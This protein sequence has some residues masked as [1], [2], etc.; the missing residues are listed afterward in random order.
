MILK[1]DV[2]RVRSLWFA[3]S[4]NWYVYA[5]NS[6]VIYLDLDGL[7]Y[8]GWGS[9]DKNGNHAKMGSNPR[10]DIYYKILGVCLARKYLDKYENS[11]IAWEKSRTARDNSP[12]NEE[13]RNAEHYLYAFTSV[14]KGLYLDYYN[15][16]VPS[17]IGSWFFMTF[18]LTPGYSTMKY[19][20]NILGDYT[21][22]DDS[23]RV[24]RATMDELASGYAGGH[25]GL[26]KNFKNNCECE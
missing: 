7:R 4:R 1:L 20:S 23:F 14:N 17:G 22:Y 19:G 21:S 9:W 18:V 25:D 6:P 24:S 2:G 13:L 10:K 3:G 26:D 15:V 8:K 5:G 16:R 11:D 12:Y